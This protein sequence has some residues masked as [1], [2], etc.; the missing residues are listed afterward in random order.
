MELLYHTAGPVANRQC[1]QLKISAG[2]W[3]TELVNPIPYYRY[4]RL[5]SIRPLYRHSRPLLPYYRPSR[6][7]GNPERSG[8]RPAHYQS[9]NLW[10][11]ACTG[12]TVGGAGRPQKQ[13]PGQALYPPRFPSVNSRSKGVSR[14]RPPRYPSPAFPFGWTGWGPAG[15]HRAA[16]PVWGRK[17]A[18]PAARRE[19]SRPAPGRRHR[20]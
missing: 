16:A 1:P 14:P 15:G 18:V 17:A 19:S 20:R 3:H 2:Q 5:P 11:P 9:G 13:N 7:I 4:S 8:Q 6:A 10:I 12:R